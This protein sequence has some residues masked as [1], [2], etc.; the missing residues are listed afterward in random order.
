MAKSCYEPAGFPALRKMKEAQDLRA[1]AR[2][3]RANANMYGADN[4]DAQRQMG[5]A[6]DCERRAD[7]L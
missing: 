7:A 5:A 1:R 4:E 2:V 6:S 3:L